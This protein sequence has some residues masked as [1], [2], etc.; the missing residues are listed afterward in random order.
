M[1]AAAREARQSSVYVGPISPRAERGAD[2]IGQG[3]TRWVEGRTKRSARVRA[4][5]ASLALARSRDTLPRRPAPLIPHP[6]PTQHD[7][8]TTT[9]PHAHSL[10]PPSPPLAPFPRSL[11]P[12]LSPRCVG[13]K[14]QAAACRTLACT[15]HDRAPRA[16]NLA[17]SNDCGAPT[18]TRAEAGACNHVPLLHLPLAHCLV[19]R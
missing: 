13:R 10:P 15:L 1:S 4:L 9:P 16:S 5:P 6:T 14:A 12:L 2:A 19:E 18:Q 8:S 7:S 11:Q 17:P 3:R